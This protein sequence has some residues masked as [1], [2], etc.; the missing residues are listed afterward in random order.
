MWF[1]GKK[2]GMPVK[3]ARNIDLL[4]QKMVTLADMLSEAAL[5][6][7]KA[8]AGEGWSEDRF[9]ISEE[10]ALILLKGSE[11]NSLEMH[12]WTTEGKQPD[13]NEKYKELFVKK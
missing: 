2:D 11:E 4:N 3:F 6:E 7:V 9:C 10:G 13:W 1:E 5:E 12:H 8:A